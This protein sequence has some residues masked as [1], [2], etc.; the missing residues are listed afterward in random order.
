[1]PFSTLFKGVLGQSKC[2]YVTPE[3]NTLLWYLVTHTT[4]P[5]PFSMM[6][7]SPI[8][9]PITSYYH[10]LAKSIYCI[11]LI[12]LGWLII[13]GLGTCCSLNLQCLSIPCLFGKLLFIL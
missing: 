12:I 4:K 11:F 6:P 5:K 7:S 10:G 9:S 13:P 1:M 3:M 2:D 8:S